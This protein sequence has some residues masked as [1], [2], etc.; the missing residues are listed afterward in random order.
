MSSSNHYILIGC[1]ESRRTALFQEA[2]AG[3][4]MNAATVV[5]CVDL[6]RG[7]VELSSVVKS[8]SIVRIDS[9]GKDFEAEKALL[10][11]GE[12]QACNAG[13]PTIAGAELE[14]LTFDR[15]RI[16]PQKQWYYGWC[17]V[18]NLIERQL[19]D[20]SNYRLIN[21]CSDIA[22]MFDKARCHTLLLDAD[23]PV[24]AVLGTVSSFAELRAAME[25]HGRSR[26]F[27]KPSHSSSASGMVAYQTNGRK[28]RAT[29]TVEMVERDGELRLYNSRKIRTYTELLQIR[30]LIDE[31]GKQE[32][33]V[34]RWFPK[35]G[36][37]GRTFDLR[38][39]LIDGKCRHIVVRQSKSTFTNLHLLNRRGDVRAVR[40]FIGEEL[41][42][43][44]LSSC[45]KSTAILNGSLYTGVD[46][47]IGSDLRRHAIAE[48][49]AFGDLLPGVLCD[50]L[51]TYEAEIDAMELP[52]TVTAGGSPAH[53]R[54][55]VLT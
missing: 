55:E 31:L 34:E 9:P 8:G 1:P 39:V 52:L 48:M 21:N 25:L 51:S 2:L 32:L 28:H 47:L 40:E 14:R 27:L 13:F 19:L 50:G 43:K 11:L 46:V 41:W 38:V 24:T 30:R 12:E 36:M 45:E 29:T 6:I 54:T 18:L 4:G 17:Q 35:A 15:G 22:M 53:A 26:V 33:F 5:P 20:C 44:V 3:L 7:E 16:Y 10:T 49:N 42:N 23:V 37:N